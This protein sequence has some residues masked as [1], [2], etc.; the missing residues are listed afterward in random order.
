VADGVGEAAGYP[1]PWCGVGSW[2]DDTTLECERLPDRLVRLRLRHE[3]RAMLRQCLSEAV[4][5]RKERP[6]LEAL[7]ARLVEEPVELAPH[8]LALLDDAVYEVLYE[9]LPVWEFHTRTGFWPREVDE[10]LRALRRLE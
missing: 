8:E 3:E 1:C 10:L 2:A 6:R 9:V 4:G 5:V 7:S